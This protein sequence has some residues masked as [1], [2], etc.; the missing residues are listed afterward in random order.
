MKIITSAILTIVLLT[1]CVSQTVKDAV[2]RGAARSDR[3]VELME[4][5]KTTPESDQAYI[6]A[7]RVSDHSLNYHLNDAELPPD[8]QAALEAH[9]E[10]GQ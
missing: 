3:Y 10:D 8:V 1:G 4:A 2:E 7:K 5:G 6:K 9:G